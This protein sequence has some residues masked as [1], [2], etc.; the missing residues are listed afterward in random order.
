MKNIV[1]FGATGQLG[2][3]CVREMSRQGYHVFAVG[4]RTD[5]NGFFASLGA[6][7]IGGI[8]LENDICFQKLPTENICAVVNMAGAMPAHSGI[9]TIPYL[10]S[11]TIGMANVCEWMRKAG[12]QRIIYNTTPSDIVQH[13]GKA[14]PIPEDA[15]R[16]FPQDGGDHAVY[17]IAKNSAVDLLTYYRQAH[18]F[19]PCVFRHMTVYGWHPDAY[20]Y[21][22]GIRKILPYRHIIRR[23]LAG[24]SVEV[25][26]DPERKKELL[27]IKDF[28][29]A[30][31]SALKSHACGLFN[32][33]G[34]RPY[35]LE[36]QIDG[37]IESFSPPGKKS[38]KVYCPE[39]P[40]TP[41]NLLLPGGAHSHLGWTPKWEWLEACRDMKDEMSKNPFERLW[42]RP[43][44]EDI[45]N[46]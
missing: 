16:S 39:K 10:Q 9:S 6:E 29:S 4:R 23:C 25:W 22:N 43:E 38:K 19:E 34:I 14:L 41:Q 15:L 28:A 21:S 20:F 30:V 3:Y 12:I 44:K 5:D 45:V 35:T 18:G 36:E 2:A 8:L 33:P 7:F 31:S 42:G 24:D 17:A 26:G 32:L 13:F 11:I 37:F 40:D 27:Y 1:V 46:G